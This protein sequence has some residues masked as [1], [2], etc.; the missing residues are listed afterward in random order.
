[1]CLQQLNALLR[2]VV[3]EKYEWKQVA[4]FEVP[5]GAA[6][7]RPKPG[8]DGLDERANTRVNHDGGTLQV[9]LSGDETHCACLE[10]TAQALHD[11]RLEIGRERNFA[12]PITVSKR[13]V[14][15]LAK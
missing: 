11:T 14:I 7:A 6:L 10:S 13:F 12:R 4:H 8:G 3:G 1:M 2:D 5:A 9:V 15:L